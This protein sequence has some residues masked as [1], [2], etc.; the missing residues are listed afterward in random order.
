MSRLW[1]KALRC[2]RLNDV[3]MRRIKV[4][5]EYAVTITCGDFRAV[6]PASTKLLLGC[7]AW[8]TRFDEC[9]A[10]LCEVFDEL[11]NLLRD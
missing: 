8:E 3:G 11:P 5:M 10:D 7:C 1:E 4:G 9:P 6:T 2:P